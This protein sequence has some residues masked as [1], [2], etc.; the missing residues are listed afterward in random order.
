MSKPEI[1]YDYLENETA[2]T[3]CVTEFD[4]LDRDED[5]REVVERLVRVGADVLGWTLTEGGASAAMKALDDAIGDAG[6]IELRDQWVDATAL[7]PAGLIT[8]AEYEAARSAL[9][10]AVQ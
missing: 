5:H 7:Y 1:S 10:E 8:A 9:A 6:L 4:D 3:E 2:F